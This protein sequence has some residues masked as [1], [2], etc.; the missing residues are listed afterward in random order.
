M[1]LTT[2]IMAV[3]LVLGAS[4]CSDGATGNAQGSST[5]ETGVAEKQ[6]VAAEMSPSE[7]IPAEAVAEQASDD[8]I[9]SCHAGP[10]SY[11]RGPVS[12]RVSNVVLSKLNE[13]SGGRTDVAAKATFTVEN[14]TDSPIKFNML[15]HEVTKLT[16]ANGVEL[17]GNARTTKP[18]NIGGL[19][20]CEGKMNDCATLQPDDFVILEPGESP[21]TFNVTYTERL[22]AAEAVSVPRV[23]TADLNVQL[24]VVAPDGA[25]RKISASFS[26]VPIFN[27]LAN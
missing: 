14:R 2:S 27:G 17:D 16:L 6:T 18:T 9:V 10:E 19:T 7:D 21:A 12:V 11:C 13:Y 23:E 20:P 4:A 22:Q 15:R 26:Q 25:S 5:A 8:A 3:S 1:R 24:V